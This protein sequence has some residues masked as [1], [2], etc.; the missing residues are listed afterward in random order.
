M[1]DKRDPPLYI[2]FPNVSCP[3]VH[4]HQQERREGGEMRREEKGS[5]DRD[6]FISDG[7]LWIEVIHRTVKIKTSSVEEKM[8]IDLF[9]PLQK[10]ICPNQKISTNT[11]G[12]CFTFMLSLS[13]P[14]L[15]LFFT[16]SP[17][18]LLHTDFRHG[19]RMSL[20]Q[21]EN[22]N[23]KPTLKST[24]DLNLAFNTEITQNP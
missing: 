8:Q 1:L 4:T 17:S 23:L 13:T 9:I 18:L 21:R 6:L 20:F 22:K 15:F 12:L 10:E 2:H 14:P 3:Q 19:I 11:R 7:E 5:D 16:V 24:C